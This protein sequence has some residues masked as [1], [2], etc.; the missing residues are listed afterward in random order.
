[1]AGVMFID[2]LGL[3]GTTLG[4]IQFGLDNFQ[5]D[6][7]GTIVNLKAGDGIGASN[8]LVSTHSIDPV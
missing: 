2:A 5:K 8:T 7:Q 1:M 3:I 6:P 4:I